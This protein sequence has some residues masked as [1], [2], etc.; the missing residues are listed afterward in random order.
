MRILIITI[1]FLLGVGLTHAQKIERSV[2][3]SSGSQINAGNLRMTFTVGE[4]VIEKK[5]NAPIKLLQGF[6]ARASKGTNH[7][8]EANTQRLKVV[9]NPFQSSLRFLGNMTVV[10]MELYAMDGRLVFTTEISGAEIAIPELPSGT[11]V[12]QVSN[13]DAEVFRYRLMR[14]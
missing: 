7:L 3:G 13:A 14:Q 9:P 11:Y 12:L 5:E 8:E 6:H 1:A 4:T 2:I 10:Q